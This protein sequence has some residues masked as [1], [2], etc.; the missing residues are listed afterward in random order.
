MRVLCRASADGHRSSCSV[1]AGTDVLLVAAE[2]LPHPAAAPTAAT[3]VVVRVA[4]TVIP[5]AITAV[6]AAVPAAVQAVMTTVV[7]TAAAVLLRHL[8]FGVRVA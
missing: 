7:T 5:V 4:V 2:R 3:R 8:L 1:V 6:V